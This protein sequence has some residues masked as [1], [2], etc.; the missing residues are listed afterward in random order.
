M[1]VDDDEAFFLRLWS[2]CVLWAGRYP[3]P[4]N[5]NQ[6]ARRR[7]PARSSDELIKRHIKEIQKE[8]KMGRQLTEDKE[9][10]FLHLDVG[11]YEQKIFL[12][13]FGRLREA[14]ES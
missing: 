8:V 9:I 3:I 12:S 4:R 2:K 6:L 13:L 10:D 5:E 14:I 1:E 11:F 7:D